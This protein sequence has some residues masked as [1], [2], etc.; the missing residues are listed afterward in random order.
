MQECIYADLFGWSLTH[1]F[2]FYELKT[3]LVA[4]GEFPPSLSSFIISFKQVTCF[5]LAV[6]N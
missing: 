1:V 2:G 6:H 4:K 3:E 5:P